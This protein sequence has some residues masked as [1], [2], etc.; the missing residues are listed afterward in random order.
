LS[1]TLIKKEDRVV[2]ISGKDRGKTGKVLAV[3]PK[4][5][6]LLVE[7]VSFAKHHSKRQGYRQQG[8]IFE[9]EASIHISN[10]MLICPRCNR[11]T[12]T[13]RNVLETGFGVRV[14]KKC[15]EV[16]ERE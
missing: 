13:N 14:C 12:R 11:Q 7:R 5:S 15:H 2:V 10:V 9:R 8:G 3:F 1:T 6:R 4:E 16:A